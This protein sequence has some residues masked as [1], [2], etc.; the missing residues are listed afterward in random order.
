[1]STE[2]VKWQIPSFCCVLMLRYSFMDYATL[3]L[4][5]HENLYFMVDDSTEKRYITSII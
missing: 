3:T 2:T 1:M 4:I 5:R